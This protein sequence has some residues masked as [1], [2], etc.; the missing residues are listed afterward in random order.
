MIRLQYMAV[1]LSFG[2]EAQQLETFGKAGWEPV[3][4][5]G[6]WQ[7]AAEKPTFQRIRVVLKR[8]RV[9]AQARACGEHR[10]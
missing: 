6:D 4:A 2:S 10:E 1:W 7:P 9:L 3:C 5:L 8:E